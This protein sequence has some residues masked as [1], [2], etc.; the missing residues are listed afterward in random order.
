MQRPVADAR[1]GR[2]RL[3]ARP[4]SQANNACVRVT[5]LLRGLV[6]FVNPKT[7]KTAGESSK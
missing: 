2:R 3:L 7:G 5:C 1:T 6:H 4:A